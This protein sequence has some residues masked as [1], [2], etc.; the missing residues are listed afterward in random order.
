MW[1]NEESV[2]GAV[3]TVIFE[4]KAGR[5]LVVLRDL[6]PSKEAPNAAIASRGA[7][8]MSE[9]TFEQ[10]DALLAALGANAA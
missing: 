10:L 9:E 2:D 7:G 4:S 8:G 5:T 6:Y 1:T 3:C